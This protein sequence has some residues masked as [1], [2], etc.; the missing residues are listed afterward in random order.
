MADPLAGF[1]PFL[2]V[3]LVGAAVRPEVIRAPLLREHLRVVPTLAPLARDIPRVHLRVQPL[4]IL[5]PVQL[6][7]VLARLT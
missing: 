5:V 3:V 2:R 7:A 1:G 6:L 4:L